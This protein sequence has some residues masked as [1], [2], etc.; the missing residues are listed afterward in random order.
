MARWYLASGGLLI[1]SV[2]TGVLSNVRA[3]N[4]LN[5]VSV[6]LFALTVT[7]AVM[8]FV[9]HRI[10]EADGGQRERYGRPSPEGNS[11][12]ETESSP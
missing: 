2:L 7:S 9:A 5:G 12:T 4:A 3:S 1:L 10:Y 6:A 11:D 8:I